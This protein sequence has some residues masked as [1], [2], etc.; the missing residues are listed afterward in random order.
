[1]LQASNPA[2][3]ERGAIP[4]PVTRAPQPMRRETRRKAGKIP[5]ETFLNHYFKRLNPEVAAS[6]T[7]EQRDAIMAMFGAREIANHAIEV[8]RSIS[9]GRRRFYLVFLMGPE[10]RH[11]GRLRSQAAARSFGILFYLG[12]GALLSASV[13]ALLLYG[14]GL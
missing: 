6:F 3:E 12:A 1:M 9:F 4:E 11:F 5:K 8:R 2:I 14:T 13:L 10:Q 7:P